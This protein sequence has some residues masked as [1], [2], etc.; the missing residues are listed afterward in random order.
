MDEPWVFKPY[1]CLPSI[2]EVYKSTLPCHVTM[3][4][5][6]YASTMVTIPE[7][8]QYSTRTYQPEII[9]L[10]VEASW[11]LAQWGCW[12]LFTLLSP[13]SSYTYIPFSNYTHTGSRRRRLIWATCCGLGRW[14]AGGTATPSSSSWGC[15]ACWA[16]YSGIQLL[17]SVL[18]CCSADIRFLDI[19]NRIVKGIIKGLLM[20]PLQRIPRL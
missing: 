19:N 1:K 12:L 20:Q 13:S 16:S 6:G 9:V 10:K 5:A 2:L 3:P 8:A 7:N 4:S 17:L 14:R 11:C 18:S 15:G